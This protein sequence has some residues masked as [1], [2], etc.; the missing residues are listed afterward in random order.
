MSK[1]FSS[2]TNLAE[3]ENWP[4][5]PVYAT[6]CKTWGIAKLLCGIPPQAHYASALPLS[7]SNGLNHFRALRPYR[8]PE[9]KALRDQVAAMA[10]EQR[11]TQ[12]ADHQK[13]RECIDEVRAKWPDSQRL[14]WSG[15]HGPFLAAV[16]Q[17]AMQ[18]GLTAT[19]DSFD[20]SL[21]CNSPLT[22]LPGL[23]VAS[24]QYMRAAPKH[25][26]IS[27][28]GKHYDALDTNGVSNPLALGSVRIQMVEWLRNNHPDLASHLIA[29]QPWWQQS[30][31]MLESFEAEAESAEVPT[32]K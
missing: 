23:G 27:M 10:R 9:A 4:L 20:S 28:H 7:S 17:L 5:R 29:T 18:R 21:K 2:L 13:L 12:W 16:Q 6:Q 1:D 24:L 19:N 32:I 11:K 15:E 8:T 31:E 30:M 25:A 3:Q 26:W 22:P 14:I